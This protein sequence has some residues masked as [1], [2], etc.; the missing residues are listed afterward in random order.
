MF[1]IRCGHG[2]PLVLQSRH[3]DYPRASIPKVQLCYR[4]WIETPAWIHQ[5]C[6]QVPRPREWCGHRENRTEEGG[7]H[8]RHA[9]ELRKKDWCWN[10]LGRW[11]L[12]KKC[13]EGCPPE[14]PKEQEPLIAR[15]PLTPLHTRA[16]HVLIVSILKLVPLTQ[17]LF[18][19]ASEV[20]PSGRFPSIPTLDVTRDPIIL[21]HCIAGNGVGLALSCASG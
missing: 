7:K 18:R 20:H 2:K 14:E 21:Q 8:Q 4:R 5:S 9:V 19:V 17:G 12:Q 1:K 16:I 15:E 6:V 3:P 13:L 10:L 11:L